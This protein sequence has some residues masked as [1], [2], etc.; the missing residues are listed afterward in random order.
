MKVTV[1]DMFLEMYSTELNTTLKCDEYKSWNNAQQVTKNVMSFPL[2]MIH[3][4]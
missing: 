3:M 2:Y 4:F 1:Q